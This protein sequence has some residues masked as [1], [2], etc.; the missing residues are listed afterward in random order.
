MRLFQKSGLNPLD[1]PSRTIFRS[2]SETSATTPTTIPPTPTTPTNSVAHKKKVSFSNKRTS[3]QITS[4]DITRM[5][6]LGSEYC[7]SPNKKN[8]RS[9][10]QTTRNKNVNNKNHS[11]ESGTM[12]ITHPPDDVLELEKQK[13]KK[14]SLLKRVFAKK[15]KD[16]QK[17]NFNSTYKNNNTTLKKN[18][19]AQSK[20]KW[21][22]RARKNNQDD[23][24]TYT[25]ISPASSSINSVNQYFSTGTEGFE[26]FLQKK[27]HLA[28]PQAL[29]P[30]VMEDS[31]EKETMATTPACMSQNVCTSYSPFDNWENF[32]SLLTATNESMKTSIYAAN[33]SVK[34][35][36]YAD[37]DDGT[38]QN[39][40]DKRSK[41]K[42]KQGLEK[43]KPM[44][45]VVLNFSECLPFDEATSSTEVAD[46][47][48]EVDR[49][50]RGRRHGHGNGQR[51]G[52]GSRR[53]EEEMVMEGE[54]DVDHDNV[55]HQLE[56]HSVD[57][58]KYRTT[59]G[60]SDSQN[61]ARPVMQD[62]D[63]N[64]EVER[65]HERKKMEQQQKEEEDQYQLQQ[66]EDK[67]IL[68]PFEVPDPN[69]PL[70]ETFDS[71]FTLSFLRVR[72]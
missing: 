6:V 16:K 24:E 33:E 31:K 4:N 58:L 30:S 57:T 21:R 7:T 48:A 71:S 29:S 53:K 44:K 55:D 38:I 26:C 20:L 63:A 37:D 18:S 46:V 72:I 9:K 43:N 54:P 32:V 50:R 1:E 19:M 45:E 11:N 15:E 56:M 42:N 70:E 64:D 27:E 65:E 10:N 8:N 47:E 22:R 17:S 68:L 13:K 39:M 2:N 23:N 14:M 59:H 5:N 61:V 49:R 25:I 52:D 28:S 69:A 34:K 51:H 67:P 41:G 3:F 60:P 36:L 40:D 62:V 12:I 66:M 35:M